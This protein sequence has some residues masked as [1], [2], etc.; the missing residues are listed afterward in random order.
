M[1]KKL[2]LTLLLLCLFPVVAA[3]G[4][5]TMQVD[6]TYDPPIPVDLAG[7]VLYVDGIKAAAITDP[8]ARTWT[9]EAEVK[10]EAACYTLTAIDTGGVESPPSPCFNFNMPPGTPGNVKITVVVEVMVEP[11]K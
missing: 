3:A 11:P 8:I 6:W 9:G 4:T 5:R 10:D 1:R 7:F 2:L